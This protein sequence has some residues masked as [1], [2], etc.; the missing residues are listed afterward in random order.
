M[1]PSLETIKNRRAIRAYTAQPIERATLEAILD[2]GRWAPSAMNRQPY[3]FVVAAS[4]AFRRQLAAAARPYYDKWLAN[5]ADDARKRISERNAGMPDPVYYSAAA[6]VFVI[7]NGPTAELDC[8][9]VCENMMLAAR[10]LGLGSCWVYTGSLVATDPAIK[11]ALGLQEGERIFGPI[12]LGH[13]Q[14]GFPP[15][16]TRQPLNVRWL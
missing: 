14:D 7:G 2:A 5:L 16:T 9:M 8:P 10:A 11:A 1:N 3:R 6:V 4:P 12:I 13:P 15:P